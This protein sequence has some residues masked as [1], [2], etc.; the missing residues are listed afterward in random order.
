MPHDYPGGWKAI[1][2][3]PG[4]TLVASAVI[5][6]PSGVEVD[7]NSSR[8]SSEKH[9]SSCTCE[10][11]VAEKQSADDRAIVRVPDLITIPASETPIRSR[12]RSGSVTSGANAVSAAVSLRESRM[13][14]SDLATTRQRNE[15]DG[16]TTMAKASPAVTICIRH[17]FGGFQASATVPDRL[18]LAS[19]SCGSLL[20]SAICRRH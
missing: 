2:E 13:H 7:A 5:L 14:R 17:C 1:S 4:D 18:Q 9:H 6:V 15:A 12:I 19:T 11:P 16:V 10:R 20:N 8:P 3:I